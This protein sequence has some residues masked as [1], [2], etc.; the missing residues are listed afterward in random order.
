MLRLALKNMPLALQ[1]Y[2]ANGPPGIGPAGLDPQDSNPCSAC[3]SAQHPSV[4]IC[5]RQVVASATL[6]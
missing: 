5:Y 4:S 6:A 3:A 1:E 2:C